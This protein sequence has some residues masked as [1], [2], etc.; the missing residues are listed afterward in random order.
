[1][2]S[3][4]IDVLSQLDNLD[5]F[6]SRNYFYYIDLGSW[7]AGER[8]YVGRKGQVEA[9]RDMQEDVGE[10]EVVGGP[11]S[12]LYEWCVPR[13]S[14]S[15][16]RS[17]RPPSQ[18]VNFP[19]KI[20]SISCKTVSLKMRL[21]DRVKNFFRYYYY[22][23]KPVLLLALGNDVFF[24]F[25]LFLRPCKIIF[26]DFKLFAADQSLVSSRKSPSYIRKFARESFISSKVLV[27]NLSGEFVE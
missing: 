23:L 19:L 9:G 13:A 1:M 7:G 12:C 17:P 21:R 18:A 11:R 24:K 16:K 3:K 5:T 22:F 8:V 2:Y 6:I 25:K 15:P 26:R 4:L 14:G 27:R 10:G 20:H